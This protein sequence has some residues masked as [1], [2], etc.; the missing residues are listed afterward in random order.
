MHFSKAVFFLVFLV[1]SPLFAQKEEGKLSR[2]KVIDDSTK[3]VYGPSTT[4]FF[5]EENIFFN[6]F[7]S[8][9]VDTLIADFHLY[10]F[11]QRFNY[12]FQD[13]GNIATASSPI[14][15]RAPTTTG[16]RSGWHSF[17]L[18]WETEAVRYYDTKSP[19]SNMHLV[20][21]GNGRSFTDIDYTRNIKPNWNFG[22]NYRG[23][24]MDKQISRS[25][26]GDR[27]VVSH[28]YDLFST[29]HSKDS[30]YWAFF[31]F[32]RMS[33][34]QL[35]NGGVKVSD[36]Y[37]LDEFFQQFATPNLDGPQSYDL[38]TNL[39]FFHQYR[40]IKGV[41]VYQRADKF[42]QFVQFTD[43]NRTN[44]YYDALIVRD[45]NSGD[46]Q[47]F[48]TFT[49]ELGIK[50]LYG[51]LFYNGYFTSR[52]YSMDYGLLNENQFALRTRGTEYFVGGRV[53]FQ[54]AKEI[55]L[56][57]EAESLLNTNYNVK[58]ALNS[59]WLE[60]S[61][62][63]MLYKPSFI[64][65][66]FLGAHDV[67]VNNFANVESTQLKVLA[68]AKNK[69]ISISGG[70]T[71][72]TLDNYVFFNQRLSNVNQQVLPQ[73]STDSHFILSPEVRIRLTML[74]KLSLSGRVVYS[75]VAT[76]PDAAIQLPEWMMHGQIAFRDTW[77]HGNFDF[78]IG[79]EGHLQSG[80]FANGY[81]V[82][83]QQFYSQQSFVTNTF[84]IVDAFFN[85]RMKRGRM[86]FK[87]NNIVQAFT[88]SGYI[89]TPFYPGQANVFDFG[90]DWIF[91]D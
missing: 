8:K 5:Y 86:F 41:E 32:R 12:E 29:Y 31:N 58:V 62:N 38:R 20:L 16:V 82:P 13:L 64:Q 40:L 42:R 83:T 33:H 17:D 46:R 22:F 35:E 25:G 3:Q 28:Y 73:Q 63:R 53:A 43:K 7:Q 48:K 78:Q 88:N 71:L 11:I 14:F 56:S 23:L 69:A 57:G 65:Q 66:L 84:P 30:A 6:D 87:Y 77:V 70:G 34:F 26:R 72:T 15:F 2:S 51:R 81:D 75:S 54:L 36:N 80:Y 9:Q 47:V 60:A 49:N 37:T 67:W 19:F 27:N 89:V 44:T 55:R 68:T 74:K 18:Y 21:G 59:P 50:G 61:I 10:N 39:H 85:W 76:N 45:P 79:L 52:N 24:F 91:F 4:R 1:S 90:F